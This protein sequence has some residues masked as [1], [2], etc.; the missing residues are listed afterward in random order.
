[1]TSLGGGIALLFLAVYGLMASDRPWVRALCGAWVGLIVVGWVVAVALGEAGPAE[2]IVLV[3]VILFA[4][5]VRDVVRS[6]PGP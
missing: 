3:F 6:V 5:F 1:V 2:V 4:V